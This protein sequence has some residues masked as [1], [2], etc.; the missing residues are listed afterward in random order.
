MNKV[1]LVEIYESAWITVDVVSK[2]EIIKK[3]LKQYEPLYGVFIKNGNH[4]WIFQ[5]GKMI[6]LREMN[7]RNE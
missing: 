1:Y 5:K 7:I 4:T 2:K 6:R 3:I